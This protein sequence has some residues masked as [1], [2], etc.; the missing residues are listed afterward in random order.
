MDEAAVPEPAAQAP[1]LVAARRPQRGGVAQHSEAT[2]A[3]LKLA[4]AKRR[5]K[6]YRHW[7]MEILLT[8]MTI[9]LLSALD[10]SSQWTI[11]LFQ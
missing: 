4:A 9:Q 1:A 6:P 10:T 11:G 7:L 2:K 3:K 8:L 5:A